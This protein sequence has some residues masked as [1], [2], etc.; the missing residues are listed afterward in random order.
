MTY[1]LPSEAEWEYAC[2]AGGTKLYCGDNSSES[3]AWLVGNSGLKTSKGAGKQ[4]NAWGLY[5]MSG[6]VMEWTADC[7]NDSYKGAPADGSAWGAMFGLHVLRGGSWGSRPKNVRATA[8]S[9]YVTTDR[10]DYGFRLARM[11]P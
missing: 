2:K 4:A 6:N 3:V 9:R 5:D 7:W 8:R 10:G 11:L 1:R